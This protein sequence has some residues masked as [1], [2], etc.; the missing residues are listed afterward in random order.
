MEDTSFA[1]STI[2]SRKKRKGRVGH[3]RLP[4]LADLMDRT[5]GDI[6]SN[7]W[8]TTCLG[9]EQGCHIFPTLADPTKTSFKMPCARL[10]Y[11]VPT[12]YALAWEALRPRARPERN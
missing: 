8:M 9:S 4:E 10:A 3:G 5:K 7:G 1:Y 12:C 11:H 6:E 2:V